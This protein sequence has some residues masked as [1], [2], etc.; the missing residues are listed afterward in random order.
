LA[1]G[2][3]APAGAFFAAGCFVVADR[4]A[5]V[6]LFTARRAAPASVLRSAILSPCLR[7]DAWSGKG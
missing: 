5:F 6:A 7:P 1:V 4:T 3:F 2:C